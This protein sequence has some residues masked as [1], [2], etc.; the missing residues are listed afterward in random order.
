M[1]NDHIS[2]Y[3]QACA[4]WER[5]II[6]VFGD[7]CIALQSWGEKGR[8]NKRTIEA[9]NHPRTTSK[10]RS[11]NR[12]LPPLLGC[13]GSETETKLPGATADLS[14]IILGYRDDL[15]AKLDFIVSPSRWSIEKVSWNRFLSPI[16]RARIEAKLHHMERHD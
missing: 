1:E 8:I 5:D 6:R 2:S 9:S 16:R 4:Q 12:A 10:A 7:I 3:A 15:S 14:G 13:T 11:R